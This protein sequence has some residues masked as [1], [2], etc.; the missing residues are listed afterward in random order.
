MD[1]EVLR[2]ASPGFP[3]LVRGQQDEWSQVEDFRKRMGWVA[4]KLL[5][6]NNFVILKIGRGNLRTGPN[7]N[8]EVVAEIS[9]G[10]VMQ[11]EEQQ[12][13]WVKVINND[14]IVGWV[15]KWTVWP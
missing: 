6:E 10:A 3:L 14:G 13:S 2:T 7:L 8:D 9:Y 5:A 4:N 15:Q 11:I 12:E 1:F